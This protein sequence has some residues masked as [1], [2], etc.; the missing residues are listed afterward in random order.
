[1][2]NTK[3]MS[4]LPCKALHLSGPGGPAPFADN[5]MKNMRMIIEYDGT[6]YYGWQ[7]QSGDITIQQV[8]EEILQ[9]IT[10]EKVTLHGSS[11]TDAGVHALHQVAHFR[12][13]SRIPE[14]NLLLGLN[15]LIPRN[16]VVKDLTEVDEEFHARYA[17]RSKT[18]FY[19]I[20]NSNVR[21]ALH[22]NYCWCVFKPL[23]V[24][25]MAEAASF[26]KGV[27]DF[28]A[29]CSAQTDVKSYV[30]EVYDARFEREGGSFL[31]F[32]VEANGFLRHMVRTIVGT[33][34]DVGKGKMT[35]MDFRGILESRDRKKAGVTAPP[36]GLFL[37]GVKYE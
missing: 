26:L 13:S 27:H 20:F 30:R 2:I 32:S 17:A 1:L 11:R 34:V 37:A 6:G 22:R 36:Q 8:L 12:T 16:I 29:F 31:R 18:Y 10:G 9:R 33:L 23:D 7:R 35:P 14:R 25:V 4:A 24:G 5:I 15:S 28:S 3:L 19:R 21:T